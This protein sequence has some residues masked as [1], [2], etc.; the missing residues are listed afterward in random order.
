[1]GNKKAKGR[2]GRPRKRKFY[3]KAPQ[4]VSKKAA[5]PHEA[6]TSDP[7]PED[8]FDDSDLEISSSD[9]STSGTSADSTDT[10][11]DLSSSDD[12]IESQTSGYRL[13]DLECL[14]ILLSKSVCCK[15]C[16]GPVWRVPQ[17]MP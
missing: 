15:M 13:V 16:Q 3:G 1:M 10:E 2:P 6:S 11:E 8:T 17:K 7:V 14:A 12:E 9:S 4:T 5:T